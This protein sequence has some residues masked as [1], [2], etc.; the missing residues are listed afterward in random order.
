MLEGGPP[1]T[2]L[3][4]QQEGVCWDSTRMTVHNFLNQTDSFRNVS[5][6]WGSVKHKY[7]QLLHRW[8]VSSLAFLTTSVSS[9]A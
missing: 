4:T 5:I 3:D 8:S 7:T 2:G 6:C 9:F 1:G